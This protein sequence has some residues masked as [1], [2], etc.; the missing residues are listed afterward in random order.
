MLVEYDR[1]NV[2]GTRDAGKVLIEHV[3]DSLSCLLFSP[4][5]VANNLIDIGSGGGLPAVP[6]QMALPKTPVSLIESN[7]KKTNFLRRV[8]DELALESVQI[9]KARAEDVGGEAGFR[10]GYEIATARALAPLS[11]L[12]E[13]CLPFVKVGGHVIAMKGRPTEEEMDAGERAAK[14][15]GAEVGETI[16]VPFLEEVGLTERRL[17]VVKKLSETPGKYPRRAGIPK[18]RPLGGKK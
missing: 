3:I 17:V 14:T 4:I 10:E 13:Y 5:R 11:V 9:I 12:V 7:G 6:L 15:L 2:I 18:K 1:A 8:V 16:P